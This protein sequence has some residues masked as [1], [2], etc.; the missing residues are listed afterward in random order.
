MNLLWVLSVILINPSLGGC[1]SPTLVLNSLLVRN[2]TAFLT[3]AAILRYRLVFYG[4]DRLSLCIRIHFSLSI[5]SLAGLV[6]DQNH[7]LYLPFKQNHLLLVLLHLFRCRSPTRTLL[8]MNQRNHYRLSEIRT[9]ATIR[10]QPSF[11]RIRVSLLFTSN[12]HSFYKPPL[13]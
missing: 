9:P 3:R 6:C 1:P 8:E 13:L 7:H 12:A 5:Y 4:G 11:H 10:K 2:N